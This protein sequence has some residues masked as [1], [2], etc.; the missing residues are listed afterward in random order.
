MRQQ[1]KTIALRQII[2]MTEIRVACLLQ[3]YMKAEVRVT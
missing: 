2:M 1:A 3:G